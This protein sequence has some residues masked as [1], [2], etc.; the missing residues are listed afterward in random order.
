MRVGGGQAKGRGREG[1]GGEG[2]GERERGDGDGDGD[3]EGGRGRQERV[4]GCAGC[5]G[6]D[7]FGKDV[8]HVDVGDL[9]ASRLRREE[10]EK[11][12][13][14]PLL[15]PREELPK[16]VSVQARTEG[17]D[18]AN[19]SGGGTCLSSWPWA[20]VKICSTMCPEVL[21]KFWGVELVDEADQTP[22]EVSGG[23]NKWCAKRR[24]QDTPLKKSC[25]DSG[26]G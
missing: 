14:H 20:L 12:H 17:G 5:G 18:A 9:E 8:E 26:Y 7:G 1:E 21:L 22:V 3:G 25:S 10:I 24:R 11:H 19:T 4:R 2:V 15:L 6:G 23:I 16:S 13:R